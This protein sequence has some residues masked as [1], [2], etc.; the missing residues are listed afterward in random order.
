MKANELYQVV[1]GGGSAERFRAGAGMW[2]EGGEKNIGI[3]QKPI[4]V[5]AFGRGKKLECARSG[6]CLP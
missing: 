6:G 1:G 5:G 2:V 4:S 3:P